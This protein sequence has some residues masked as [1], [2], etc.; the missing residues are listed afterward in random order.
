MDGQNGTE[1]VLDIGNSRMKMGL[2]RHGR[3]HALAKAA[4]G[5][6][7]AVRRFVQD[8][9]PIRCIVGSVAR[10]DPGF[11]EALEKLAPVCRLTGR[12]PSPVR[13]LYRTPATFGV[14]RLA[15]VVAA[16]AIFP[17]RTVL[18]IDAGT[19]ITCD[20]VDAKGVH[21]GGIISPGLRMRAKAMHDY[22]A[23]LPEVEAPEDTPLPGTDTTECL[24]AGVHHGMMM[25]LRG[26]IR[27]FGD[28]HPGLAVVITGG[29]AVR[30]AR[31]LKNGIFAHPTLTLIGL[32]VLAHHE[33]D[34]RA[35][36]D[37]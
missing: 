18:A 17:G 9:V 11:L 22:S 12:S 15:N 16:A 3:P 20:L 34:L 31:G 25:E 6:L 13:S 29:D 37:C 30:A 7:D 1:L 33:T 10:P 21:H 23:R 4:V 26:Y 19:C 27:H 2:F 8:R 5:D 24:A 14:D 32:H 36:P 28:Q 35:A